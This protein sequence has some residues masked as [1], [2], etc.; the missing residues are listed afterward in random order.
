MASTASPD[1]ASSTY[2]LAPPRRGVDLDLRALWQYR[3]LLYFFTWRD[4]KVRYKQTILGAA[5]AILQP[6]LTTL[7]FTVF[8]GHVAG[9]SSDGRPYVL[10]AFVALLPWTYFANGLS[11]AANSLV[12]GASM[13]TK[14][15]FPRLALPI[16]A[17]LG[18]V[19][20]FL[21]AS[22]LLVPLL[23]YYGI[24]PT[25][26]IF[27]LPLFF[28]LATCACIGTGFGLAALNVKYRDVRYI[29]PFL[30]QL[31]LF[32]TPVVY[33][34]SALGSSWRALYAINPMVGVV[35]GFRWSLLGV[36]GDHLVVS[37]LVS[38]AAATVLFALGLFY[39][40]HA[41]DS[42]ADVI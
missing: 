18:A 12:S 28:L 42:F 10:F 31:W 27:T 8:F 14:V 23:A 20:D 2:R 19:V 16:A 11:G 6:L 33:S 38:T 37:A 21:C 25:F 4:V 39:F 22:I 34:S 15:Y 29:V 35:D 7:V 13:I 26:R 32:A 3:Q 41:E 17:V 1:G 9:L 24:A 5:W 36:G 40:R 30:T